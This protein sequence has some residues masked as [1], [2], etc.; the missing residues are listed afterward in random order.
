MSFRASRI[1]QKYNSSLRVLLFRATGLKVSV[2]T[3]FTRP[4]GENSLSHL[5]SE[6]ANLRARL[7]RAK[8]PLLI[9]VQCTPQ[10]IS[11]CGKTM[12][13]RRTTFV[14][15][16]VL[17][18]V[19]LP[20]LFPARAI[21]TLP[22]RLKDAD[23]WKLSSSLSEPDGY[24]HSDNF[25]SNERSFQQVLGE[26]AQHRGPGSAYIGVGPEQNF[27][28]LLAVKPRIAFIVDIRRQN[29]IEHLMYKALFELSADRAEFLSR[30]LSRSRPSGLNSK[31]TVEDLFS[32]YGSA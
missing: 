3:F 9:L 31:S 23:F 22:E 25:V 32:A 21:E 12:K 28:Y 14:P 18:L 11:C 6:L 8:T 2:K 1:Q 19:L 17:A 4:V 15:A 10:R 20:T 7:R 29:L 24:F 5:H 26:L 16:A 27:T 13:R 30:L